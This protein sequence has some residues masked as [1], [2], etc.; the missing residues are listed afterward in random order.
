MHPFHIH[1][2]Y[3]LT[4]EKDEEHISRGV[5]DT[6]TKSNL[7]YSQVAPSDMFTEKNTGTNLPAQVQ[8]Y[9]TSGDEYSF[10]FVA[11]GGGSANKTF[12][13]QKTKALLNPKALE[14]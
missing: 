1:T 14:Q 6:Y 11:K 9:A 5:Y 7:R 8:I 4:D 13:Y 10:Q 2:Q 12:L 3:V